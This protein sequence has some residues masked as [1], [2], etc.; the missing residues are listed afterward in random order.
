MPMMRPH[1]DQQ[2]YLDRIG[3][4]RAPVIIIDN[5]MENP[6]HMV[7]LAAESGGFK[8]PKHHLYPGL[9]APVPMPYPFFLWSGV[10]GLILENFGAAGR[11]LI[12][13]TCSYS[14]VTTPPAEL[15]LL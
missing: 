7:E 5:F 1:K 3:E 6:E 11:K 4:N 12:D 8:P 14:L 2:F 9:R 10:G 13:F 15:S